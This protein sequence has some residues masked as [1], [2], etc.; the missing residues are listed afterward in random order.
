MTSIPKSPGLTPI[1]PH[2]YIIIWNVMRHGI[3]PCRFISIELDPVRVESEA[4]DAWTEA[5]KAESELDLVS[6][7]TTVPWW[8]LK[9]ISTTTLTL[10]HKYFISQCSASTSQMFLPQ[11]QPFSSFNFFKKRKT[12]TASW[13]GELDIVVNGAIGHTNMPRKG[14]NQEEE[15]L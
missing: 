7:T 15:F 9:M 10:I 11:P 8:D 4:A 2:A 14:E 13:R 6:N 1:W 3:L 12:I 5:C